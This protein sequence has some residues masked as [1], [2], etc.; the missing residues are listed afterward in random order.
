[1]LAVEFGS[2]SART[3]HTGPKLVSRSGAMRPMNSPTN[4]GSVGVFSSRHR[5]YSRSSA[6]QRSTTVSSWSAPAP[7]IV[8]GSLRVVG[9]PDRGRREPCG[10]DVLAVGDV[11]QPAGVDVGGASVAPAHDERAAV[12]HRDVGDGSLGRRGGRGVSSIDSRT[13]GSSPKPS[14]FSANHNEYADKTVPSSHRHSTKPSVTWARG[15]GHPGVV[16]EVGCERRAALHRP[17][18]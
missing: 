17:R 1:M 11:T 18:S 9:R 10:G 2:G 7:S 8:G 14:A 15:E 5:P 3:L 12:V 6:S 16:D 4:A 13:L